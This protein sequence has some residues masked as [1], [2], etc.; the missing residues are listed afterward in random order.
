MNII[1]FQL[2]AA[3]PYI[4]HEG[5]AVQPAVRIRSSSG[6]CRYFTQGLMGCSM[7]H[8]NGLGPMA[9]ANAYMLL[10]VGY[11][12]DC[13]L[14]TFVGTLVFLD[15]PREWVLTDRLK[16]YHA[17]AAGTWRDRVATWICTRMLDPFA[18]GGKH[19]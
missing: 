8:R 13:A 14:N 4:N 1:I 7:A 2:P 6:A 15:R 5:D 17:T 12:L 18:P 10:A 3:A 16:R 9:R 11:V 19:C